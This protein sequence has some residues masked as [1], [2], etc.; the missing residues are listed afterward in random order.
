LLPGMS[1][2]ELVIDVYIGVSENIL[3]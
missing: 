2:D 3:W 1:A